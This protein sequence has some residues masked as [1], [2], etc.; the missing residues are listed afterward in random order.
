MGR[1]TTKPDDVAAVVAFLV[2]DAAGFVTGQILRVDG[3]FVDAFELL[4][5]SVTGR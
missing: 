2:S 5:H 1:L 4:P 3:G